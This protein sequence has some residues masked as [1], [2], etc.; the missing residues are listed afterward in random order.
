LRIPIRI[1]IQLRIKGFDYHKFKKIQLKEKDIF[2]IKNCKK[3]SIKD[4]QATGEAFSPQKRTFFTFFY[5]YR[6]FLP[7]WI[8]IRIQQLKVMRIWIRIHNPDLFY[9][10]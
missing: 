9:G 1:R 7:S 6:S 10:L 2:L 3:A 8:R 4:A 5:I